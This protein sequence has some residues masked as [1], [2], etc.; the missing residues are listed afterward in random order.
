LDLVTSL[1]K[2][3]KR[4]LSQGVLFFFSFLSGDRRLV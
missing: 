2:M 4:T 3:G 1:S